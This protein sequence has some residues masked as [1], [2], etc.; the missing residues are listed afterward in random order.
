MDRTGEVKIPVLLA[1]V[2]SA[3]VDIACTA[4]VDPAKSLL[5]F[6]YHTKLVFRI[7]MSRILQGNYVAPPVVGRLRS[8]AVTPS[9]IPSL[10][11]ISEKAVVS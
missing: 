4:L 11:W 2:L 9:P 3:E 10:N 8:A 6:Q 1:V 7:E 5:K